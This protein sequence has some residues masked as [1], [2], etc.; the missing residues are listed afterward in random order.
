MT[1]GCFTKTTPVFSLNFNMRSIFTLLARVI[2]LLVLTVTMAA[3]ELVASPLTPKTNAPAASGRPRIYFAQPVYEFGVVKPGQT[4]KHEFQLSNRGDAVLEIKEVRPSCGCTTAGNWTRTIPPNGSGAI[5]IQ[6]DT[7]H[8]KGAI[9]KTV[10]V[11]SNDPTQPQT[12]LQ[13]RGEIWTPIQMTPAFA[14]FPPLHATSDVVHTKI[15][16]VNQGEA[17]LEITDVKSSSKSF[18]A[19]L[20]ATTPG[21]EFEL[22]VTTVPPLNNGSNHGM[23]TLKTSSS[24]MPLV[25]INAFATVLPAVQVVPDRVLLPA[26]KL[27]SDTQ[28]FVTVTAND[29]V[30]LAVSDVKLNSDEVRAS[31]EPGI[32]GKQIRIRLMIP[33]GFEAGTATNLVL[34]LKTNHPQFAE[35]SIPFVGI[36]TR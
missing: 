8:F 18:K 31:V 27:A 5:A 25:M 29:S 4:I 22:T 13:L 28:R 34:R 17:P 2:P 20:N 15:K 7:G 32:S 9:S 11:T 21:K 26:G 14:T 23:I 19:E 16:L 12:I 24:E 35:F 6:L 30:D 36:R 33:K 1:F 10:T 3:A